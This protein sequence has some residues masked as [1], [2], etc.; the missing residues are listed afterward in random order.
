[1][2]KEIWKEVLGY[3]GLYEVSNYG[4]VRSKN[5][6]VDCKKY[7]AF[8]KGVLLK[9]RKDKGGY[10]TVYLSRGNKH[11]QFFVHRLV[12]MSFIEN[13]NNLPF[14]N[15]KDENKENNVVENIEWCDRMYNN[16]YGSRNLRAGISCRKRILQYDLR[17]NFIKSYNSVFQAKKENSKSSGTH[18]SEACNGKRKSAYGYLWRYDTK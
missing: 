9:P 13:S 5:R 4:K 8:K 7:K 2:S 16:N 18:I 6:Y 14:I 12:A 10:L 15:H 1:M 11:K 3:E 17:G